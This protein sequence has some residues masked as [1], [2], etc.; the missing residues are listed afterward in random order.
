MA[1]KTCTTF[2]CDRDGTT[3]DSIEGPP[4]HMVITPPPPGWVMMQASTMPEGGLPG[5][6]ASQ[7]VYLCPLCAQS[8]NS[9]LASR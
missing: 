4:D 6:P 2:V 3:S 7:T 9:F 1:M 8:F 5:M